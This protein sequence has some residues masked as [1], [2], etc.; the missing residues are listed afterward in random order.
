MTK[1]KKNKKNRKK[2]YTHLSYM[3]AFTI[4]VVGVAF[5][6]W[7]YFSSAQTK[8]VGLE[9]T[10]RT[11]GEMT[12]LNRI[13]TSRKCIST[14]ESGVLNLTLL[15]MA[16]AN[17]NDE[18]PCA[19][20][21]NFGHYVLVDNLTNGNGWDWEFGYK[22]KDMLEKYKYFDLPVAIED[23]SG[24]VTPGRLR[25]GISHSSKD[26][27]LSFAY[28]SERVYTN[29]KIGQ[30]YT[31]KSKVTNNL[32]GAGTAKFKRKE[33]CLENG[34]NVVCK[35][36]QHAILEP[37]SDSIG[38]FQSYDCTIEFKKIIS[39]AEPRVKVDI[40]CTDSSGPYI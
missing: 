7:T 16:N 8:E 36:L 4:I 28:E 30:K 1:K 9:Q 24:M 26:M 35:K 22:N 34:A 37:S 10:E 3:I 19:N 18:L 23:N 15:N 29:L 5:S 13:I 17:P 33:I 38:S 25:L 2:G 39:A 12:I 31:S 11:I 20:L 14:G 40:S 32:F 6:I 21:P 27:L